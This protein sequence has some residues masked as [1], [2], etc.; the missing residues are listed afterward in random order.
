PISDAGAYYVKVR[1]YSTQTGTYDLALFLENSD[2][3]PITG[4]PQPTDTEP[5]D[6]TN[7][8]VNASVSWHTVQYLSTTTGSI[9]DTDHDLVSYP[10]H[11]HDLVTVLVYP[12]WSLPSRLI[13]SHTT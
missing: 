3:P 11:H 8:A 6:S 5:N 2:T 9:T 10:F 1:A 13:L 12:S 4:G 7:T